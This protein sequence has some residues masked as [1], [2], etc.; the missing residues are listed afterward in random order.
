VSR[1]KKCTWEGESGGKLARRALLTAVPE[2]KTISVRGQRGASQCAERSWELGS[3]KEGEK[4]SQI[5]ILPV[6]YEVQ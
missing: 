2:K 3:R 5:P 4:D 1:A 6:K